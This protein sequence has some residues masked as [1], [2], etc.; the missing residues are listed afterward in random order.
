[1]RCS[2]CGVENRQAARFCDDCGSPLQPQCGSC[3]ALNRLA[4][5]FCDGCGASLT[6]SDPPPAANNTTG[7]RLSTDIDAPDVID[8]ERKTV[9]ALFA[10]IKGPALTI[11]VDAVRRYDGYIVQSNG[12]G[13]FASFGAPVAHEDHRQRALYAALRMQEDLKR[14]SDRLRVEGKLPLQARVGVNTGEVVVRSIKTGEGHV[15][16]TPIGH[17]ISLAARM[18]ALAPIG[19]RRYL[20]NWPTD[21]ERARCTVQGAPRLPHICRSRFSIERPYRSSR[22]FLNVYAPDIFNVS[23]RLGDVA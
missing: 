8:G 7:V 16:Y 11:M 15:E 23:D 10:D 21:A 5:K 12:D 1:M 20:T 2:K 14:Y 19:S 17:S 6:P 22:T 13:I 4:A 18:Q 3:G 9:T